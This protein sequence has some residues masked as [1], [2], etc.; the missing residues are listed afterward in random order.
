MLEWYKTQQL[1]KKFSVLNEFFLIVESNKFDY[2]S[3]DIFEE[4]LKIYL[5]TNYGTI[6]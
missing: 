2:R 6:N 3:K 1:T 4:E 5:F